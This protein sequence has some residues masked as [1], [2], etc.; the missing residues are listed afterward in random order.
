M[1]FRLPFRRSRTDD[2]ALRLY[3]GIVAQARRPEFYLRCGVADTPDGRFDMVILHT[4]VVL[5]R[6][7]AEHEVA[8]DL[9][10][11]LFDMMF[12]DIDQNLREMGIGDMGISHRIKAMAQGFYGRMAAYDA[13]LDSGDRQML[14]EALERNLYRNTQ[15][16][17][18]QV[19]AM[20]DYLNRES[21]GLAAVAADRLL[22]GTVEFGPPPAIAAEVAP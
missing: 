1:G 2:A 8:G 10:Q 14:T 3:Q 12:A 4:Y 18:D 11:A 17:A 5:R 21:T 13:G 7:R 9:A 15:P 19:A 16:S 20:A 6:L 22:A